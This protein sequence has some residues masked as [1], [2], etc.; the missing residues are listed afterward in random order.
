[1]GHD[2]RAGGTVGVASSCRGFFAIFGQGAPGGPLYCQ[3]DASRFSDLGFSAMVALA[4]GVV[5]FA[6]WYLAEHRCG[7][8]ESVSVLDNWKNYAVEAGFA[9][10][11]WGLFDNPRV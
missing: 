1:M 4:E 5:H 6:S 8:R 3:A 11:L 10:Y 2:A 7:G 9:R